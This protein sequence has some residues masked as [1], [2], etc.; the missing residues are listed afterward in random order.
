MGG[1]VQFW[2]SSHATSHYEALLL[3]WQEQA[4]FLILFNLC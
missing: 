4:L 1:A 3:A 2:F